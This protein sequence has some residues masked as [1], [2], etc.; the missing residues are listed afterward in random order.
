M[1][2]S[3]FLCLT[4]FRCLL[5]PKGPKHT[6]KFNTELTNRIARIDKTELTHLFETS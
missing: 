6:K 5:G 3:N 1:A 2:D 4:F